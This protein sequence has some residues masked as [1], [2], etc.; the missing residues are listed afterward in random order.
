M[1][2]AGV[3]WIV[4]SASH[5]TIHSKLDATKKLQI[6]AYLLRRMDDEEQNAFEIQF[7][8]DEALL[9]TLQ[10]TEARFLAGDFVPAIYSHF[11]RNFTCSLF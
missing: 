7:L 11:T 3:V 2:D 4:S 8:K 9:D 6:R 5:I 1:V 10:R